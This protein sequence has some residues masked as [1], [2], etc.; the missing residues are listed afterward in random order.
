MSAKDKGQLKRQAT[1]V[2]NAQ[3]LTRG[4]RQTIGRG[5]IALPSGDAAADGANEPAEGRGKAAEHLDVCEELKPVVPELQSLGNGN[6]RI[7]RVGELSRITRETLS[8]I[9]VVR[10]EQ[11]YAKSAELS[12]R[13]EV[14]GDRCA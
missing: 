11:E 4:G 8:I 7:Y 14:R 6:M 10:G 13:A 5:G 3:R 2:I 1:N 9:A 12:L